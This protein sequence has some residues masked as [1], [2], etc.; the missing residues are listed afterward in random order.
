MDN[1]AD[2]PRDGSETEDSQAPQDAELRNEG[3][4]SRTAARRYD[5]HVESATRDEKHVE[6]L[7]KEAEQALEGPEGEPLREAEERGKRHEHR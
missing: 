4:G 1:M 7:A 3:E 2:A 5:E 6:E